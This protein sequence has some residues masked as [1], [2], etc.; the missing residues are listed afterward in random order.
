VETALLL[1]VFLVVV[2][3]GIDFGR[4]YAAQVTVNDA[5]RQAAR[6]GAADP[7]DQRLSS[8]C[9]TAWNGSVLAAQQ[10][11]SGSPVSINCGDVSLQAAGP[12]TYGGNYVTATVRSPF[13]LITP[14]LGSIVHI[15]HVTG[16]NTARSVNTGSGGLPGGGSGGASCS[17]S[18][19]GRAWAAAT[20]G[21]T[22]ARLPI[23]DTTVGDSG[24]LSSSGGTVAYN[25]TVNVSVPGVL[26]AQVAFE[27]ASGANCFVSATSNVTSATVLPGAG[28]GGSDIA[29]LTVLFG[30]TSMA[31]SSTATQTGTVATVS[32]AG[33]TVTVPTG[34]NVTV[35]IPNE[36]TL[37]FNQRQPGA[38]PPSVNA[39]S[40]NFL[41]GGLL[42][43]IITGTITFAHAEAGC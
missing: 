14:L 5:A 41:P 16:T 34:T 12:D 3:I 17:P 7:A 37:T 20:R 36:A 2:L 33:T 31:C 11:A 21:V 28:P 40:I 29:D 39:I 27:T 8:S 23:A 42:S 18:Y 26:S 13:S 25:G 43:S 15:D 19:A 35:T 10:E 30:Q 4:L 9:G 6:Y 38:N 1:P 24:N 32:I 22:V